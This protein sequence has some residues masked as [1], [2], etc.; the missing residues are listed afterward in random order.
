MAV[1]LVQHSPAAIRALIRV[2]LIV[3]IIFFFLSFNVYVFDVLTAAVN[4][5]TVVLRFDTGKNHCKRSLNDLSSSIYIY[6]V[7][8]W[9]DFKVGLN[10]ITSG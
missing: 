5:G 8:V 2:T 3:I 4:H 1:P 6:K 7:A 9:L 10:Q